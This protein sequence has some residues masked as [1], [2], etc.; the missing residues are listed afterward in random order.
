[1]ATPSTSTTGPRTV[2][3]HWTGQACAL[4]SLGWI[5]TAVA[6]AGS[7]RRICE[8]PVSANLRC[9]L[10]SESDCTDPALASVESSYLTH[11]PSI[12]AARSSK[13]LTGQSK[14]D[15]AR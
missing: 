5:P 10:E 4:Y 11:R 13:A 7:G 8:N 15:P 12:H 14:D 6:S 3:L 2:R 9:I 1:M